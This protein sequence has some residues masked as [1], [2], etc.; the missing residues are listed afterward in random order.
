MYIYV[1]AGSAVGVKCHSDRQL[2][3]PSAQGILGLLELLEQLPIISCP[4]HGHR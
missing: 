2:A 3:R 1:Y 4:V